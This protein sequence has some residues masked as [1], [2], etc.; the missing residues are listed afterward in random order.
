MRTINR[1]VVVVKPLQ[2]YVDWANGC[3][4]PSADPIKTS[5]R[6]LSDD[7]TCFLIPNFDDSKK[8]EKYLASLKSKIFE[9]QLE[10]WSLDENEWPKNRN[11]K[12]FDSWFKLEVHSILLT[13]RSCLMTMSESECQDTLLP[14]SH[15]TKK[16]FRGFLPARRLIFRRKSHPTKTIFLSTISHCPASFAIV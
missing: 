15:M 10:A 9:E 3:A 6:D 11:T 7:A 5:V 16:S 14:P 8:Q 2:P 4:D 12:V 13:N 1:T